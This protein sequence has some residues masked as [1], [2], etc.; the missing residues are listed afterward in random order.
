MTKVGNK[1][2]FDNLLPEDIE[3]LEII[4]DN[5]T[6]GNSLPFDLPPDQ[7][8]RI[9]VRSLKWFWTWYPDAT[10]EASLYAPLESVI[11]ATKTKSSGNIDVLMPEGI[12]GV[13]DLKQVG[14][15]TTS[16]IAKSLRYPIMNSFRQSYNTYSNVNTQAQM[17]NSFRGGY[18]QGS[19]SMNDVVLQLYEH[20]QYA[21]MF[22]RGYRFSY[23][24]NTR[25]LRLMTGNLTS[26]FV[27]QAFKRLPPQD[28]YGDQVF[29]DYVTAKVEQAIGRIVTTF[30]FELPGSIKI[31]YEEIKA[32]G[33][34]VVEKIESE[35]KE[36]NNTDF[37]I[38]A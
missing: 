37:V 33:R 25:I 19:F 4:N 18:G 32:N 38:T 14:G 13:F 2:K 15:I 9:V 34:D 31:N 16:G 6:S 7:I 11:A 3:F 26:G 24:K 1:V 12:E 27:V 10:Q 8:L 23:N 5:V 20:Q 21:T 22:K 29:E 35:I 30:D 36:S 28:L 17:N